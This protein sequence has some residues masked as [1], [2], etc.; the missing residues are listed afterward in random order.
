MADSV[1]AAPAP[2]EVADFKHVKALAR[3]IEIL[4]VLSANPKRPSELARELNTPWA[5]IYR[6]VRGLTE[7]GL[8]QRDADT[9]A[10]SIGQSTWML[11]T[12]YLREHPVLAV[13]LSHLEPLVPRVDGLLKVCERFNREALTLFAQHN[14]QAES[15]RRIRDQYRLDLH[16]AAFGQ[17]LLAYQSEAFID[18][19]LSR[20]LRSLTPRT[21]T[22]PA[23]IREHLETIRADGYAVS[24]GELELSNG[25][26]AV[27]VF[28]RD[29]T[30]VAAVAAVLNLTV[31]DPEARLAQHL[32]LVGDVAANISESLGWSAYRHSAYHG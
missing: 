28:R 30:V 29:G 12:A 19:Y 8:L 21:V 17:V 10:Y 23:K 15:V 11:A 5:T 24:R 9:G 18:D 1:P 22:D 31:G 25:S 13:G 6:T 3:A 32:E 16:C 2:K 4:R 26:V 14:P 20:P 7:Q 27:P